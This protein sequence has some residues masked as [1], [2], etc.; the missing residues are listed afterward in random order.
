M[1]SVI[2]FVAKKTF[3]LRTKLFG[4]IISLDLARHT[5]TITIISGRNAVSMP[6]Q[7]FPKISEFTKRNWPGA[8]RI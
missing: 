1:V 3:F 8:A 2:E 5:T 7:C 4:A 6:I